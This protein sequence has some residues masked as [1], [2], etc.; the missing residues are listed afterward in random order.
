MRALLAGAAGSPERPQ[1]GIQYAYP[2]RVLPQV[3]GVA[4]DALAVAR[5]GG[6]RR[7]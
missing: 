2:F 7:S 3:D 1:R 5:A 6:D 4:H